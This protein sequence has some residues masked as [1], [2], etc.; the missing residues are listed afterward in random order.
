MLIYDVFYD[1]GKSFDSGLTN[2]QGVKNAVA[3]C[4]NWDKSKTYFDRYGKGWSAVETIP[5]KR[6]RKSSLKF[7]LSH[8][9]DVSAAEGE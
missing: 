4:A 8:G 1:D 3:I 9:F 5:R 6:I 7:V 2:L